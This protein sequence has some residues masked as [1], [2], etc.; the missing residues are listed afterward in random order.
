MEALTACACAGLS[1]V[2]AVLS[3]DPSARVEDLVL[4]HKSGGRS[5]T[6]NRSPATPSWVRTAP[7]PAAQDCPSRLTSGGK[8]WSTHPPAAPAAPAGVSRQHAALEPVAGP[9]GCRC[10][11][12][13]RCRRSRRA[14]RD[15]GW[16]RRSARAPIS[17]TGVRET[18][19]Q[20]E[21]VEQ[22]PGSDPGPVRGDR[23][24]AP[25]RQAP[26]SRSTRAGVTSGWSASRTRPAARPLAT[27]GVEATRSEPPMP[28]GPLLVF[29]DDRV[30]E[31]AGTA[32]LVEQRRR[33]R[34]TPAGSPARQRVW[35]ARS[36]RFD[37]RIAREPSARRSPVPR[38]RRAR[39]RRLAGAG[40]RFPGAPRRALLVS[41]HP[42]ESTDPARS[43]GEA[44]RPRLSPR[45]GAVE[46]ADTRV[47]ARPGGGV[48]GGADRFPNGAPRV[49]SMTARQ[50]NAENPG[51][52]PRRRTRRPADHGR[53][54]L[55][56]GNPG[57][58]HDRSR[59]RQR[60]DRRLGSARRRRGRRRDGASLTA[61]FIDPHMHLESTKL[62]VDEFVRTVMPHGTTA[63]AA[64]P[65]EIANVF[66]VPGVVALAEAARTCRSRSA[67]AP[68]AVCP[69]PRSRA[70]PRCS[71]T[72]SWWSSSTSTGPSASP[73]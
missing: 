35:T 37:R 29:D 63:V 46:L 40:A 7:R 16:A 53:Q 66:G 1:V 21:P 49:V 3:V 14:S 9:R 33:A 65:H 2:R 68:R 50:G 55:R 27:R 36:T 13:S 72:P 47:S 48:L 10:R 64:D 39:C 19:R 43:R 57:V 58:G 34:R 52:C 17:P 38:P 61:G 73:R 30:V 11:R 60:R 51:R 23:G 62:W 28:S 70:R 22:R 15:S 69:P 12:A 20:S 8:F 6:W 71:T 45:Q 31:D 5:G 24:R 42:E 41:N 59:R 44:R 67:S 56:A 26:I 25:A 4:L 32:H 18:R 54:G